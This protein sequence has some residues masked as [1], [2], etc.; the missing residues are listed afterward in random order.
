MKSL[1]ARPQGKSWR[2][3]RRGRLIFRGLPLLTVLAFF[4]LSG[5][6]LLT[7]SQAKGASDAELI[8]PV[9]RSVTVVHGD[10]LWS[11]ARSLA[12]DED[13]RD[14]INQIMEI[15]QLSSGQ[16]EAGQVL[17]VPVYP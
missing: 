10:N 4:L 13:T 16:L 5:V 8:Q 9:S 1:P 15:N 12:P 14:V 3:T 6:M 17:E 11:I 7:P 2:L